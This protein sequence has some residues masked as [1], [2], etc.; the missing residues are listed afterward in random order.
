[1][2]TTA[3]RISVIDHRTEAHVQFIFSPTKIIETSYFEWRATVYQRDE[4]E[5]RR[6]RAVFQEASLC[7][8]V[9]LST[10][11]LRGWMEL[12]AFQ[13]GFPMSCSIHR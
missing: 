4:V 6:C 10:F 8:V 3:V 13:T 7:A 11:L 9:E 5:S 1:M 2:Q 12:Q